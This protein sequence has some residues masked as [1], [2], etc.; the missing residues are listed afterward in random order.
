MFIIILICFA[1]QIPHEFINQCKI[2]EITES[3]VVQLSE[4]GCQSKKG[5]RGYLDDCQTALQKE[6][7][8]KSRGWLV[9]VGHNPKVEIAYKKV[10]DG[11][12]LR[13]WKICA[14]I[15]AP[16]SEVLH[17]LLRERH[18][19]DQELQ[20][21]KIVAQI[22]KNC[23]IFQY[24]RRNIE[25]LPDEEYCVVRTWKTDLPKDACLIVET[26]VEHPDA[27]HVPGAVRGIVLAS[28]Y[29][30]E[31]CG[32]GKSRLL[33]HSRIDT[34]YVFAIYCTQL[35]HKNVVFAFRGRM[36]EWYHKN[37]GHLCAILIANVQNSF[38][39][40][41]VGPESKV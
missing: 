10:A 25:P 22:D 13:L 34:R 23:E 19:W 8:E 1:L 38:R 2:G 32:S 24:V 9:V 14:D 21:A 7:R 6:A 26:S 28:R 15:E 39:Q 41:A 3:K 37:Y 18:K 12:P 29:L 27:A 36:P 20:S 16:P 30:I 31:P 35:Q 17:R 5:W 4:L 11:H 40:T 33:H